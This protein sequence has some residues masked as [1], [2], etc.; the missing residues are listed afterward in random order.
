V[1]SGA[2]MSPAQLEASGHTLTGSDRED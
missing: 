1:I 2:N